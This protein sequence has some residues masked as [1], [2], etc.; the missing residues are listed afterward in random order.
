[1]LV[2]G[3]GGSWQSWLL[4][5]G[6]LARDRRVIAVDLPG[7]GG[8]DA[9]DV[10]LGMEVYAD[11]VAALLAALRVDRAIAVGHSLGGLVA[12]RLA[13]RHPALL[14]ALVV[15]NGGGVA[16]S[17]VRLK[18]VTSALLAV[19]ALLSHEPVMRAV[20]VRPRA[21]RWLVAGAI[22]ERDALT[23]ALAAEMLASFA[24]PGLVAAVIA[25]ARDD[26]ADHVHEVTCP[27]LLLWGRHDRLVPL[28]LATE[29]AK[30][31]RNARVEVIEGAGH[32][33]MIERPQDFNHA[34]ATFA[35]QH[36]R[37]C[38]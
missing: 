1:V 38:R 4:N 19:N 11:S 10:T 16:L 25:G 27:T 24:A 22:R 21:R 30:R 14:T 28:A 7:F 9:L 29:L 23:P 15:V 36:E 34:V 20:T 35:S 6:E 3:T 18:L 8:S 32:C 2:H 37:G 13:L 31:M 26:V 17:R 33:P 5:L 12:L